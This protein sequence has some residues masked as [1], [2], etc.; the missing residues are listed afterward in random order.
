VYLDALKPSSDGWQPGEAPLTDERG[1]TFDRMLTYGRLAIR[2]DRASRHGDANSYWPRAEQQAALLK[3][4]QPSRDRIRAT[5]ARLDAPKSATT[6][7]P[8]Q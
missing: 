8:P 5:I 3:W 6:I 7:G 2:A 1:L 4:E